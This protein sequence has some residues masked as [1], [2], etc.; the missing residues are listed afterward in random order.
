[1]FYILKYIEEKYLN[2]AIDYSNFDEE[3][4]D[5]VLECKYCKCEF[6]HPYND[7]RIILHEIV[8]KNIY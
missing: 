8:D 6:N 1:M 7:R 2:N 5:N 4:F 3:E